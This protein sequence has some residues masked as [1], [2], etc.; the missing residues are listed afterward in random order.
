MS[1][2]CGVAQGSVICPILFSLVM[3]SL[4]P[5]QENTFFYK[6]ADDLTVLYFMPCSSNDKLQEEIDSIE[7][8]TKNQSEDQFFE[9][10]FYG[11]D[12]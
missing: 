12:Y 3:D 11:C 5:V 1:V 2:N 10:Q 6:Y 7:E 9:N 4:P 8:W